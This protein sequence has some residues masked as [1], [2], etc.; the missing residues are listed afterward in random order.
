MMVASGGVSTVDAPIVPAAEPVARPASPSAAP[1]A[2]EPPAA[3]LPG[4]LPLALLAVLAYA[5]FAHGATNDPDEARVQIAL[6]VV[7]AVTTVGWLYGD[8][9]LRAPK[10]AWAGIG[11][12]GAFAAWSGVT[13]AWSVAPDQ[14]WIECNRALAYVLVAVLGVAA[15]ASA[16]RAV[17]RVALGALVLFVAVGLYAL[18]GKVA[19]GVHVHGLFDFDQTA[20]AA[21]LRAP[22]QY[23]NALA[24]VCVLAIPLA[25]VVAVDQAR[26]RAVRLAAL[27][28]IWLFVVVDF[29]TYSR[30]S[31]VA[32]VCALVVSLWLGGS[33]LR[34]LAA[35]GLATVAAAPPL[36][37]AFTRA[38]LTG[39]FLSV[40]V[41]E[42]GGVVLGL[43]CVGSLAGLVV[44]GW[45]AL[46]AERRVPW[47]PA[48]S[49]VVGW[50]L[51]GVLCLGLVAGAGKVALSDR[52]VSGS[53]QDLKDKVT[54]SKDDKIL[55]PS[56]LLSTNA[57]NRWAWWKE[58]VGAW[59]DRPLKGGGAG[60]FAVLHR[61]YRQNTVSVLQPH[62]VPL[63]FLAETG[64]PGFLL[65]MGGFV[66]L[67][68]AAL[69]AARRLPVR[70][71]A[72]GAA[73]AAGG[74]AWLVHSAVDWDFDI[75]GITFPVL[76][77][78]GVVAGRAAA[79]AP[80]VAPRVEPVGAPIGAE[81]AGGLRALT[82]AGIGLVLFAVG[83]SA[84]L[85]SLSD[86]KASDA[87]ASVTE[88]ATPAQLASAAEDAQ[89]A[90]RLNPLS[91]QPLFAA[92]SVAERRKRYG[93]EH[94]ALLDAVDRE[95]DDAQAWYRLLRVE[96]LLG[97]AVGAQSA[98][99]RALALDP[100][101]G[102]ARQLAANAI[103]LAA[104]ANESAT[105]V[106]TP[107][108]GP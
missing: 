26:G 13:L 88:T 18:A 107:L 46:I 104:P 5:A 61:Q 101:D 63:Q 56:R 16:R 108:P 2:A 51:I 23:W 32:L 94:R 78:A 8:V 10:L 1:G 72:L 65:A 41:R 83:V 59:S 19:P 92:A 12:L 44:A 60:S 58:A 79:L 35:L 73:L 102:L 31:L 28:A 43:V 62:S 6:A 69:L 11:L 57:G 82:L 98:A 40:G 75:P 38:D 76:V 3:R 55:D 91:D 71:R 74:V 39:N 84:A 77:F 47:T 86:T 29:L 68:L 64:L 45:F 7:A 70:E 67:F 96:L 90:A 22:L 34:S 103:A 27:C 99:L 25:T 87:L 36:A 81:R 33:R 54:H 37:V 89:V 49:R 4:A 9:R 14:T 24:F 15:G 80:V 53:F 100:Y 20:G 48:R 85:P 93:D 30:G 66:S 52:G 17:E 21:R 42:H 95:P 106:G 105:A 50:A 97:D